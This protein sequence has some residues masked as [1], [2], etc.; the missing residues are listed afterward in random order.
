[1]PQVPS[2]D[3]TSTSFETVFTAALEEYKKQTKKDLAAHPLA[4][5]L[6][7]CESPSAIL[8]VLRDQ[9]HKSQSADN[10]KL[11]KWLGP[12]VNVLYAFSAIL[13][14]AVGLVIARY[15]KLRETLRSD[16]CGA[17]RYSHLR[18]RFFLGLV[19]SS[20]YAFFL[21]CAVETS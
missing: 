11:T 7:T 6:Q 1:M 12:T 4:A 10:E 3:T 13:G 21:T 8:N 17:G 15:L 18:T 19:S 5:Q 2:T 16:G 14:D 20:K 9:V